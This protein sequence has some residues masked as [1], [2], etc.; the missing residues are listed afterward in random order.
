M[1]AILDAILNFSNCSRVTTCHQ[2]VSENRDPWLPRSTVKQTLIQQSRVNSLCS[3]HSLY[4]AIHLVILS[5]SV[6]GLFEFMQ[7]CGLYGV[8][9]YI[10]KYSSKKGV[11]LICKSTYMKNVD[12]PS[13]KITGETIQEIFGSLYF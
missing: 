5:Q 10:I 9:H 2:A 13:F 4:T 3:R 8:N 11:M 12:V 1:A 7:I 6:S